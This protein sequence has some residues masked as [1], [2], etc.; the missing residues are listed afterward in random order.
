M[1]QSVRNPPKNIICAKTPENIVLIIRSE[2]PIIEQIVLTSHLHYELLFL[3]S[4]SFVS[5]LYFLNRLWQTFLLN[6]STSKRTVSNKVNFLQSHLYKCDIKSGTYHAICVKFLLK[7]IFIWLS[8]KLSQ[9][10][11]IALLQNIN[12]VARF[13]CDNFLLTTPKS[14]CSL[15]QHRVY[16][17]T[18]SNPRKKC[19]THSVIQ[20]LTPVRDDNFLHPAFN[21]AIPLV[22]LSSL[23]FSIYFPKFS[24]H[25]HLLTPFSSKCTINEKFKPL[26]NFYVNVRCRNALQTESMLEKRTHLPSV[27]CKIHTISY[28]FLLHKS[29]LRFLVLF[30]RLSSSNCVYMV[31]HSH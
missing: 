3:L 2:F 11:S 16:T 30:Q 5:L 12:F 20:A 26:H 7:L 28:I 27:S 17:M 31:R 9:L 8:L 25:F 24:S 1:T 4:S 22:D 15:L 19:A 18:C 29:R 10:R 23:V 21:S 6:V 13:S 14:Y